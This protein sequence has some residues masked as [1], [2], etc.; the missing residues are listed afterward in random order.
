M[1]QQVPNLRRG[2]REQTETET[3]RIKPKPDRYMMWNAITPD[4]N[5]FTQYHQQN[6][7]NFVL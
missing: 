3:E 5:D 2:V 4:D 1:E 7:T 6:P